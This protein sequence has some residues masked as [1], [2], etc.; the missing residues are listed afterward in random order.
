MRKGSNSNKKSFKE[1]HPKIMKTRKYVGQFLSIIVVI[2]TILTIVNS[3]TGSLDIKLNE[4]FNSSING[5]PALRF[6]LINN[7]RKDL[8]GIHTN[9]VLTCGNN[10]T[11]TLSEQNLGSDYS[12]LPKGGNRDLITS[13]SDR[14]T[15]IVNLNSPCADAYF[16]VAKYVNW[17]DNYHAGL[18]NI[19][20]YSFYNSE[21]GL[22]INTTNYTSDAW[23]GF[24]V[25]LPCEIRVT[26]TSEQKN[27]T[28]VFNRE[29]SNNEI[30]YTPF[31]QT[32]GQSATGKCYVGITQAN[33]DYGLCNGKTQQECISL[34]CNK[35]K[36]KFVPDIDCD[37]EYMIGK[38]DYTPF[39][40]DFVFT[41]QPP[42]YM[43]TYTGSDG[44]NITIYRTVYPECK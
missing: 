16:T 6:D 44:K 29:F 13:T 24:N 39:K 43:Y 17:N 36:S 10:Y 41:V 22:I 26:V 15:D 32:L 7:Y 4:N 12:V 3:Y 38:F 42:T 30:T 8:S 9:V 37:S 31:P 11:K 14:Y 34:I 40:R 20:V 2:W 27:F 18:D 35:I 21:N 33:L 28:K 19:T 1:K 23:I 5:T 25:C